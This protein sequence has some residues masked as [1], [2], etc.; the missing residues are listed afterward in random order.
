[1]I[2]CL[3][4]FQCC[5]CEL[6]EQM[7]FNSI[8]ILVVVLECICNWDVEYFYCQDS[9]FWYLS[10]FLE[11]EVVM[12][13]LFGCEYGEYVLFCC[14]CDCVREIWNGYCV[15]FEGV[16]VDYG[17]DDVFFINDIDDILFGLVEGCEWVYYDLGCDVVFDSCLMGWINII[18]EWVCIGVQFFGEFVVFLYL[19]YDMCLFKS[20]V[21]I[22][23][24][25]QVV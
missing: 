2:I 13:L 4:E 12:V 6:M 3:Q 7:E 10:G 8:V 20:K 18:C 19:L 25:C 21:E 14:E 17:V 1:M 23:F 9:D 15:G 22:D 11:V 5:C 24:M 16:V